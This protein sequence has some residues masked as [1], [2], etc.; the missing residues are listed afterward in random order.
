MKNK[1]NLKKYLAGLLST[2]LIFSLILQAGMVYA[3]EQEGS[4]EISLEITEG[5][6]S[7]SIPEPEV[8][9]VEAK[10]CTEDGGGWWVDCEP[11]ADPPPLTPGAS[12]YVM[13][14]MEDIVITSLR[15]DGLEWTV[16]AYT[17]HLGL[18]EP[19]GVLVEGTGNYLIE[20]RYD[21]TYPRTAYYVGEEYGTVHAGE[22]TATVDGTQLTVVAP[23]GETILDNVYGNTSASSP[24]YYLDALGL[25]FNYDSGNYTV[26]I[27]VDH[28][29]YRK[30]QITQDFERVGEGDLE[31]IHVT[32]VFRFEKPETGEGEESDPTELVTADSG[33]GTGEFL[34]ENEMVW[35]VHANSLKGDY[36]A[37]LTYTLG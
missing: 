1:R 29:D 36:K 18:E 23:D 21:G 14:T 30:F 3:E 9:L 31:N 8:A 35:K 10:N 27:P 7:I 28:Q 33:W 5:D 17:E 26:K 24:E 32:D 34:L 16:S 4:T 11:L 6:F 2:A 25:R 15:G 12:V 22:I 20:G 13:H 37:V 19:T